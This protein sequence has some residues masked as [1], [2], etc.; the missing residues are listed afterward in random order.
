M[1]SPMDGFMQWME[2]KFVPVASKVGNQRHLAAVRDAFISIL[3]I[4]MVGSIATLLNVFVVDLPTMWLG[5]ENVVTTSLAQV[6]NVDGLVSHGSM[7][8]FALCFAFAFGYRLSRAYDVDGLAGGV[9][10]LASVVATMNFAPEFAYVLP[11]VTPDAMGALSSAGL[12]VA[13]VDGAVTLQVTGANL[14]STAL[15]GATGLF[16]ALI[17]GIISTMV[18]VKLTL[19]DVSIKLPEGVPPAVSKA[20]AAIIPGV[21]AVYV[22]AILAQLCVALTGQYPNDLIVEF[23]QKPLLGISQSAPAIVLTSFLIQLLWFFGIHGSQVMAPVLEGLYTPALLENMQVWNA[24]H[25]IAQLP[26]LWTKASFECFSMFSGAGITLGLIIAIM[27]FSKRRECR[28]VAE[29]SAPMGVFNINEPVI[30]GMPIVLNPLYLIPWLLVPVVATVVAMAFTFTGLI[31]PVFIQ[32]PWIMPVGIG[33]FLAT[34]G[35]V[36]AGL[37]AL[38][39]LLISFVIWTPFVKLANRMDAPEKQ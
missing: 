2:T 38:L 29:M 39:N 25:D 36:L 6:V 9:I 33:A 11:N 17:F 27:I 5:E 12:A 15:T 23:I 26:Y 34:G 21:V 30:F 4:T 13:E 7:A 37:V 3:P 24:T 14:I 28:V 19:K 32:V 22:C 31:P 10:A 16:S 18:Y 20:F 8:I 1:S 35:N